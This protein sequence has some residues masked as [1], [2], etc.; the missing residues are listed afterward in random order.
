M[1]LDFNISGVDDPIKSNIKAFIDSK[2]YDCES[3]ISPITQQH[4][5]IKNQLQLAIQPFGYFNS[6]SKIQKNEKNSC[7]PVSI[8]IDLGPIT[9]IKKSHIEIVDNDDQ[10]FTFLINKH[11]LAAEKP[12]KQTSYQQLKA[13]LMDLAVEKLYLD[14]DFETQKIEVFK[15]RNE[16][17]IELIFVPGKRYQISDVNITLDTPFLQSELIEKMVGINPP[18]F[19]THSELYQL[20]RKLNSYGYFNQVLFNLDEEHKTNTG[21]PLNIK[22]SAAAKYDYAI[23]AGYSTDTGAK[24]SFSYNN[25]RINER[26]H[27]FNGQMKLSE[28]RNELASAY[29]IPSKDKPSNKWI[30]LSLVYRDELTDNIDSET[31]KLGLSQTRIYK[32]KWQ[33]INFI[34]LLHENF[35]TGVETGDSLLLVPGV[36]WSLTDTDNV[37]RP[38][39]GYR[40]QT[41][42]KGASDAI[43]SDASFVQLTLSG[44]FI[45]S[46]GSKNRMLYRGMLGSTVSS[47]FDQIPTTYRFFA[48]GDQSIRG[49]DYQAISP[50]NDSGD[51]A[52]G[53][54]TLVGSVEFE[55]Q[56]TSQWALAVFTDFGDAFNDE[57]DFNYSVGSGVRWFSPIGPIRLDVGVPLDE[58]KSNFRLHITIGPDL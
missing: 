56:L 58:D 18:Q 12:F 53:K 22:L 10:D 21:L 39:R 17:V 51:L 50:F 45:H 40:I 47:D 6:T 26:G 27:Q 4:K 32:N 20:K 41:E 13:Q 3:V 30:N 33:N 36:S 55:Y 54:H 2:A 49:Y 5:A 37:A 19:I 48:G 44:K 25:Y 11:D 7:D 8:Q 43:F 23:G 24:A 14:A 28:L 1:A 57:F 29:K 9:T 46:L 38:S 35:D 16:A 31:S 34:D 42:F 52:G 15:S